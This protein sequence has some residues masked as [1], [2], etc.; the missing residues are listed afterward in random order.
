M[1]SVSSHDVELHH[2]YSVLKVNGVGNKI[3]LEI[4]RELG[5][6]MRTDHVFESFG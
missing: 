6:R 3:S 1:S 4:N 2:L 5:N